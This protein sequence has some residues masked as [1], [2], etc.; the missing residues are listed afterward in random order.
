MG[1][2]KL[3][4]LD[5]TVTTGII[6]IDGQHAELFESFNN[7]FKALALAKE[8]Q[9]MLLILEALDAC[10]RNHL[11]AEEEL[12]LKNNY[13]KYAPHKNAHGRFIENVLAIKEQTK[14]NG[15]T[16]NLAQMVKETIGD[17][18][19]DHIKIMDMQYVPFLKG[20]V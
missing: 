11:S 16:S 20:K 14:K 13:P 6:L 7:V 19:L 10:V 8:T 12:M 18:F 2:Y 15:V 9:E 17:W 3:Y 1:I 4:K 5:A